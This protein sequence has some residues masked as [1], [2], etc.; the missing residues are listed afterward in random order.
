MFGGENNRILD[1]I[2]FRLTIKTVGFLLWFGV[3]Y[4]VLS[5]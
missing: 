5:A 3:S 4:L 1:S 2:Y